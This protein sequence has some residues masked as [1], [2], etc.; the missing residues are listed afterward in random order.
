MA[1]Q[2]M[3]TANIERGGQ[4]TPGEAEQARRARQ[5]ALI[6]VGHPDHIDQGHTPTY[7]TGHPINPLPWLATLGSLISDPTAACGMPTT[8]RVPI[9]VSCHDSAMAAPQQQVR[10]NNFTWPLAASIEDDWH[11]RWP[12]C[13]LPT[14]I[15][16]VEAIGRSTH[17]AEAKVSCGRER[18]PEIGGGAS[19]PGGPTSAHAGQPGQTDPHL[20]IFTGIDTSIQN[21]IKRSQKDFDFWHLRYQMSKCPGGDVGIMDKTLI[22]IRM[23]KG[24]NLNVIVDDPFKE[25]RSHPPPSFSEED[26]DAKGLLHGKLLVTGKSIRA[27]GKRPPSPASLPPSSNIRPGQGAVELSLNFYLF[28]D[29][30]VRGNCCSHL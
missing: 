12:T 17:Q 16:G 1:E 21:D 27:A 2:A 15:K 22:L 19:N 26:K 3:R 24:F 11:G 14:S 6:K 30:I 5:S 10:S 7:I 28:D 4:R 25:D 23:D 8:G 20:K 29:N 13:L 18:I 9:K